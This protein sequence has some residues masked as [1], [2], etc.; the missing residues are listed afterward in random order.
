MSVWNRAAGDADPRPT[1]Q[2]LESRVSTVLGLE[3]S[4]C[5]C[6][7]PTIVVVEESIYKLLEALFSR[8]LSKGG[9]R[10][11]SG[12]PRTEEGDYRGI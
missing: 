2:F 12:A 4:K 11:C 9:F 10:G 8:A 5:L 7:S 1:V 6:D 3:Y